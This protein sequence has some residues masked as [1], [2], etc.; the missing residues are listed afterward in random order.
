MSYIINFLNKFHIYYLWIIPSIAIFFI[1]QKM[2]W[3][4]SGFWMIIFLSWIIIISVY[5]AT[6]ISYTKP[7]KNIGILLFTIIDWPLFGL[8][9]N[10]NLNDYKW[11]IINTFFI[12]NLAIWLS[13]VILA[14]I[15]GR[16]SKNQIVWVFIL[17]WV[18]LSWITILLYS[19]DFFKLNTLWY[20]FFIIWI[21]ESLVIKYKIFYEDNVVNEN[22]SMFFIIGFIFL[23]LF[24]FFISAWMLTHK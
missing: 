18:V 9:S 8:L 11:A 22:E 12:E 3:W 10:W 16:A 1:I 14:I 5:L 17:F 23:W 6:V 15:S 21:G 13:I 24:T 20:I 7:I 4:N 2:H 19:I